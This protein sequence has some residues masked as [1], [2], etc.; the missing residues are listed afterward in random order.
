[1]IVTEGYNPKRMAAS[2]AVFSSSGTL[3]GLFCTTAGTVAVKDGA[4]AGDE[5]VVSQF[6]V[7][8]GVFYCLPMSL[9]NG[10][11]LTLGGGAVV[12]AFWAP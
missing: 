7:D 2:G 8:A 11:Y 10:C 4:T 1:M 3:C 12:T 9:E 6:A 5:D